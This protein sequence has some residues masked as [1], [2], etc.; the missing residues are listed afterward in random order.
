MYQQQV[1]RLGNQTWPGASPHFTLEHVESAAGIG[2]DA[3]HLVFKLAFIFRLVVG[4]GRGLV[5]PL[6]QLSGVSDK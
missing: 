3:E 5:D 6:L 1:Y 2:R 4:T